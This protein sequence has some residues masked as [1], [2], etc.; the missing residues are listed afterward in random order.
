MRR[1]LMPVLALLAATTGHAAEPAGYVLEVQGR[2]LQKGEPAPLT[3]GAPVQAGALIMA[4]APAPGD[5]ITVVAARTGSVLATRR[6]DDP[7]ACRR[8][9]ALP[10]APA[11]ATHGFLHRVFAALA[12]QPD[13]YVTSLSRA[14]TSA[15]DEVLI[16]EAGRLDLGPML[17]GRPEAVYDVTLTPLGCPSGVRCAD[18]PVEARLVWSPRA[19]VATVELAQPGLFELSLRRSREAAALPPERNWILAVTR[20]EAAAAR[21]RLRAARAMA[22]SWGAVVDA[23]AKRAF[24]R[25]VMSIPDR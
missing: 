24:T 1:R 14:A 11:A 8:P 10:V 16:W 12:D 6:C 22:D 18:A 15:P 21:D 3:V 9:L 7:S 20:P 4:P 19:P 17:A 13:R 2:W 23:D 25:A 5:R